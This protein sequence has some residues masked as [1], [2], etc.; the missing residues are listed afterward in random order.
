MY[1]EEAG[2]LHN[3]GTD[4]EVMRAEG[5]FYYVGPDKVKY[6]VTYTADENG[7]IPHADH[8]PTP[9]PVPAAILRSLEYKKSVG[10]I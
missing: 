10:E 2:E 6:T 7:F 1:G 5:I 3:K 8:L 9:P 4:D